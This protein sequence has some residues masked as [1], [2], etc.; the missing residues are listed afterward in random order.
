MLVAPL[1]ICSL[2]SL[3][4]SVVTHEDHADVFCRVLLSYSRHLSTSSP[5]E[6]PLCLK[7]RARGHDPVW[8]VTAL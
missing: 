4:K 2:A 8:R 5:I 1:S 3:V 7:R 6:L